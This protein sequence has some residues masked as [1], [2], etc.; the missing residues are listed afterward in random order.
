M[1]LLER[2]FSGDVQALSRLITEVENQ[3]DVS[4]A[5]IQAIHPMTGRAGRMGITGPPGA[6]KSSL[7][8]RIAGE[9]VADGH[10]V[11]I[12]AVDPSSPFSGGAFLGD[13]VRMQSLAGNENIYIRSM[14]S[15]G[16]MGGLS[17]ATFDAC[18][19][20]DAFGKDW[21]IMETVGVGQIELDVAQHA[22]TIVVALSPE[23]GDSI[24]AF[25]AGLMEIGDIFVVNKADRDGASRLVAQ[26]DM[27]MEIKREREPWSYPVL[28][29]V[30]T[31]GQG[32]KELRQ[33][34]QQHRD[35]LAQD[36]RLG[37]RRRTQL[38]NHVQRILEHQIRL[39][40]GQRFHS[41]LDWENLVDLIYQK[42]ETPY[43]LANRIFESWRS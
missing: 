14:A 42:K 38:K 23:S 41:D 13:R 37:R 22:D 1:S 8:D 15:R 34:V 36:D 11:G 26:L 16:A 3:S 28:T 30:A 21:I 18:L 35:F 19:M 9:L 39:V 7:V 43:G 24:Q 33:A 2:F 20:L 12:L 5:L 4:Q 29:T 32:I 27:T 6:G 25:K 31:T 17:V 40:V 10:R